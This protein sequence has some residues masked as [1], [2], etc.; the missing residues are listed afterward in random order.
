MVSLAKRD[1]LLD[2]LRLEWEIS[3]WLSDG[4]GVGEREAGV[5]VFDRDGVGRIATGDSRERCMDIIMG[6]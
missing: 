5:A 1:G 4:V 3:T 6:P 2:L